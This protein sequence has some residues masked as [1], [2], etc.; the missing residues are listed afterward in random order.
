MNIAKLGLVFDQEEA[1]KRWSAGENVFEVF[2]FEVLDHLRIPYETVGV[3]H[4]LEDYDVIISVLGGNGTATAT[5]RK[6]LDYVSSGGTLI[7]YAG[8]EGIKEILGFEKLPVNQTGYAELTDVLSSDLPPLRY[9]AVDPWTSETAGVKADGKGSLQGN[10]KAAALQCIPYGEGSIQRWSIHVPNTIV[11]LQQGTRPVTEDG[12]PAPDGT[13]NLDENL[14]KADDGFKLDWVLDRETTETGMPYFPHPYSDLWK[15]AI[16]EHLLSCAAKKGLTLPFLDYW[17]EEVKH[18]AMISH[19]SDLN[20]DESAQITLE[21]LKAE[22]VQTTWC[23][24]SPGYSPEIYE[25]IK[26]E[27]HELALHYNALHM[28]DGVWSE[29]AFSDQLTWVKSVTG[30]SDI[31]S[32]KNHYTLFEGWGELF[33]WCEKYGIQADQTRGPSKKGNIGFL[34]GTCHPYFPVSW[35]DE[36]NRNYNVLEVGF[37]TQDL[38][39]N[40]LADSSV[41]QPFLDGV[42]RVN[43]VAHFLFHQYHIYNQLKVREAIVELIRTARSQGFTFWTSRQINQWERDRR[44]VSITG[45]SGEIQIEGSVKHDGF[46]V[47]VPVTEAPTEAEFAEQ[48]TVKRFGFHCRKVKIGTAA[49]QG[50]GE[51]AC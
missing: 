37:L 1:E 10:E 34:F 41:I 12:I 7:S 3:Q 35:A 50:K 45:I 21:T 18:L 30:V 43:G 8:L 48:E 36:K 31:V 19:D 13:A 32:N 2:L 26:Q 23:M 39:H 44:K 4:A 14:L 5:A 51:A 46:V 17:P 42:K 47:L 29:Q 9:L 28:D 24:I 22:D 40:T 15:E 27:G 33:T 38:N 6:L 16:V 25:K 20:V 49:F 11:G